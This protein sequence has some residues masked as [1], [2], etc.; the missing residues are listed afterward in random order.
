MIYDNERIRRRDRLLQEAE[1]TH[2][3][4]NG[5]YGVLSMQAEET[6]AYGIPVSYVWDGRSAI[7]I[8]CAPEGRKLRCLERCD[9]VSFC[10]VGTTRVLPDKFTTEYESIVLSCRAFLGPDERERRHALS[11]L[12]DKYSPLDKETG[13]GY[14]EKSFHRTRIIRLDI[15]SWSGKA[16]RSAR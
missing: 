8:H 10:V 2:L 13:L 9:R 1:A 5:E 15:E 7:Y 11:L 12:L 16:K 14:A 4:E 6:G 3:L